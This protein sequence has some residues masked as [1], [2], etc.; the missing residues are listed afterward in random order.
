MMSVRVQAVSI[1]DFVNHKEKKIMFYVV[2][3]DAGDLEGWTA[4]TLAIALEQSSK[5]KQV[6]V[7]EIV[8]KPRQGGGG[9]LF[10]DDGSPAEGSWESENVIKIID[11]IIQEG[12]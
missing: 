4:K 9:G 1:P 2:T 8:C 7:S 10:E 6:G 3:G 5:L 11:L 12:E